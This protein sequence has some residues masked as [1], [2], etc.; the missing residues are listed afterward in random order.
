MKRI[1]LLTLMIGA[2]AFTSFAGGLLT[3]TNQSA[4]FVRM[5][6]RNAST[7]ID[8][9]YFNPAGLIRLDNGWH[10][11][12]HNQTIFQTRDI[13]TT[14][15][16]NNKEF[17][18]EV[19]AP[20]FPTAF[21]VY[22]TDR[23]AFSLGFGPNGGGGSADYNK[24]LPS[25]EGMI[26]TRVNGTLVPGL[27]GLSAIGLAVT[28]GYDAD[29]QFSGQS[30]FWGIQLGVTGK[31]SD[32]LSGYAGVRYLPSKNVYTG[33]IRNISLKVNGEMKNAYEFLNTT[34]PTTATTVA[35]QAEA[36]ANNF[37]A[38]AAL[39][40]SLPAGD[41]VT[42]S[43]L[44]ALLTAIG[45]NPSTLNNG[46]SQVILTG[47]ASSYMANANQL[48]ATAGVL[49]ANAA[50]VA[51]VEVDTD[52]TG[53]GFTPI[54]G[55]NITPME[56]LNIGIKYEHKTYMTLVNDSR[57]SDAGLDFLKDGQEIGS[58]LPGIVAVG[59]EYKFSPKLLTSLSYNLYLDKGVN[60]GN[61]IYGQKRIID[62]NSWEIALGFQYNLTEKFALSLGGMQTNSGVSE[63]YQSDFSYSNTSN[64][65][66][67]GFEWKIMEKMTLDAGMIYTVYKEANKQ[68]QS[69]SEKYDK[70]NVA[71][72]IGIGY[73]LF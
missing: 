57:K 3:N 53:A 22:K 60:W 33:S 2:L 65:G 4:Q 52:Q 40:S 56:N 50:Q 39:A 18:G 24:G 28:P 42:N 14:A 32:A 13:T 41:P 59:A 35:G 21:A 38:G 30:V 37:T 31:I 51:D 58:D 34:A 72:G 54:L 71:F 47:A 69:Y 9:V 5:L 63:Q 43:T 45:Q 15:P 19:S 68:F 46:A 23:F 48:R 26:A 55:L 27:S 6:S 67:F 1:F 36:A 8:A 10:F 44:I 73:S 7:Q 12:L 20:I 11:A 25:F 66:A 62:K 29:I 61:N 64:S 49:K 16:L 70:S 17:T